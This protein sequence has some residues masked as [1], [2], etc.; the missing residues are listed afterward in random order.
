MSNLLNMVLLVTAGLVLVLMYLKLKK[1][2]E[3]KIKK[4]V[5]VDTEA[6]QLYASQKHKPDEEKTP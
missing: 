1:G 5:V 2:K 6:Q 3:P 4:V